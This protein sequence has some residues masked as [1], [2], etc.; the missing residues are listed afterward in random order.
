MCYIC[1]YV[2]AYVCA[3]YVCMCVCMS[4]CAPVNW[5]LASASSVQWH[6]HVF[7]AQAQWHRHVFCTHPCN[8]TCMSFTR[9]LNAL[10]LSLSP[11]ASLLL[12]LSFS[13]L[14]IHLHVFYARL[15]G[16]VPDFLNM[17]QLQALYL[18]NNQFSGTLP[19][20]VRLMRRLVL[21]Y[22]HAVVPMYCCTVTMLYRCTAV[23]S[24][25]CTDVL[26]YFHT[27]VL[28]HWRYLWYWWYWW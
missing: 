18:Y 27:G 5:R 26:L 2:F 19:F 11:S 16:T 25:C 13:L 24:H 22:C 4:M 9:R 14:I 8:G 1:V 28:Q 6:L 21:L 7:Y 10:S 23:L 12:S 20:S 3:V 17:T 15:N